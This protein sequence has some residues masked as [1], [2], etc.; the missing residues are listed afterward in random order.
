MALF[1]M[2]QPSCFLLLQLQCS[3]HSVLIYRLTISAA[4]TP[5]HGHRIGNENGVQPREC[6]KLAYPSL[7]PC[8]IQMFYYSALTIRMRYILFMFLVPRRQIVVLYY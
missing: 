4:T 7:H 5:Q 8:L 2:R 6:K 1:F 3:V